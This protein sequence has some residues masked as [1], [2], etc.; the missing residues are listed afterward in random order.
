MS[1]SYVVSLHY[2]SANYLHLMHNTIKTKSFVLGDT[3]ESEIK[4][5]RQHQYEYIKL[6][7]EKVGVE[8]NN[9]PLLS[10]IPV[11]E[12]SLTDD[13]L[14]YQAEFFCTQ[15]PYTWQINVWMKKHTSGR[16]WGKGPA[17]SEKVFSI[18]IME[19][20]YDYF[21]RPD[22][23]IWIENLAFPIGE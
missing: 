4:D 8:M 6:F 14:N 2:E 18:D 9:D 23:K 22:S 11:C 17:Y 3:D 21:P 7:L 16:F 12:A 10:N 20:Q 5:V 19:I 1:S 15:V 13:Q